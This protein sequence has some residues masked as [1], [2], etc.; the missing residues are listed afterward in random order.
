M[1]TETESIKTLTDTECKAISRIRQLEGMVS[2]P[3]YYV[4]DNAIL[5][6]GASEKVLPLLPAN[7]IDLT[8]TS[9]PFDKLR[10]YK[11]F[12]F[13]FETIAK[14]L[15]RVTKDGGVVVWVVNDATVNG[16][17]TGN[18]FRQVLRFMM[19]GFN[20]HDTMIWKKPNP[21]PTQKARY[22]QAFD[23][24]FVLSKGTPK[25]FNPLRIKCKCVGVKVKKHRA[26]KDRHKYN[27]DGYYTVG[28]TKMIDNVWEIPNTKNEGG[29]PAIFPERL[30]KD[31]IL[32]WSNEG[33][34]VL[35]CF[36]GS[37]TTLLAAKLLQRNS[38]GIEKAK[39]YCR[40]NK[41]RIKKVMPLFN[42]LTS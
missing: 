26:S 33:D 20:L 25:T 42:G 8:V 6:C 38:I 4:D 5:F 7:S 23:Y 3:P 29:H 9:P 22:Q 24:V 30:A 41:K 18:S 16:S 31:N 2:L 12:T 37:G 11:G 32:S 19:I 21:V 40:L 27:N 17:E 14:E 15:Y 34:T 39:E 1:N 10:T 28:K 36:S 13:D 35:D